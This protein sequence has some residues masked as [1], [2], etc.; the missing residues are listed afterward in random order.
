MLTKKL[1]P[2]LML[3]ACA[4]ALT[5]CGG[6]TASGIRLTAA[7]AALTQPCRQPVRLPERELTQVDIERYWRIDRAALVRCAGEKAELVRYY[8]DLFRRIG[9]K[10]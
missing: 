2:T 1:L 5:G 8:D 7:D 9:K 6:S 10:A 4:L 3:I